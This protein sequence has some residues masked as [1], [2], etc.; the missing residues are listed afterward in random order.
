LM[1]MMTS[2]VGA[3]APAAQVSPSLMCA[4]LCDIGREVERLEALGVA[5]LHF[6]IMDGRFAP[7][8]P[9]GL[10]MIRQL[11]PRTRLPFDV[12]LMVE[13][14][15]WFIRELAPIGVQRIAVHAESARSL[16]RT[17]GLARDAGA[18]AG[19]AL[20]PATPADVLEGALE[21]IDFVL[22]MTVNPGFA[23][24]KM[25]AS[26]I[27][28]I[29]RCRRFL[30][31]H[32]VTAPIEVDGN[33][34]FANIPDMVAAGARILVAGTSSLFAPSASLERNMERLLNAAAEGLAR[35]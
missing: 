12:H 20:S 18:V 22:V 30:D 26:A 25:V 7:N 11:R 9:L 3:T 4:D 6:D 14:N 34:S 2:T 33:V 19:V 10:E 27:A 5:M 16:K 13:D 17:L 28:K 21:L 8:M 29:A 1:S 15:D 31:E 35:R 32:G 24:Q 23:G